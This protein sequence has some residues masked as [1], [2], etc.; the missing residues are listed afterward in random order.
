MACHM[1]GR[2]LW[3]GIECFRGLTPTWRCGAADDDGGRGVCGI[4]VFVGFATP[5][6]GHGRGRRRFAGWRQSAG[7]GTRAV[8]GALYSCGGFDVGVKE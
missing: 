1:G 8:S 6:R 7:P 4:V 2:E 3:G 5:A